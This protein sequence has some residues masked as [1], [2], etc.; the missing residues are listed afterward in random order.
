[1][2]PM[3]L[4]K[5]RTTNFMQVQEFLDTIMEW[6]TEDHG[7]TPPDLPDAHRNPGFGWKTKEQLAS[8]KPFGKL[9]IAPGVK[10]V[11]SNLY[12]ALTAGVPPYPRMPNEGPF[13]PDWW[14]EYIAQW[15]DEGMPG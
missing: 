10:G 4:T 1:M 12:K 3:K 5:T 11:D 6:W 2:T 13:M 14:T 9:M 7:G 8:S 15:I